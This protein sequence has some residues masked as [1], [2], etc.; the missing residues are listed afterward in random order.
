MTSICKR[1]GRRVRKVLAN[2]LLLS[3]PAFVINVLVQGGKEFRPEL[4][5]WKKYRRIIKQIKRKG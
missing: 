4:E 2:A 3:I 5:T 1:L